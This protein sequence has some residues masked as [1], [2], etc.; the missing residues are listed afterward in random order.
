MRPIDRLVAGFL[1]VLMAI[2]GLALWIAVPAAVLK[3]L[4]PLSDSRGYHL[5]I[6]LIGV[7]VAMIAFGIALFWI[8]GLYL[9]IT[10]YWQVDPDGAPRRLRGPLE[11][12]LI[13]SLL[14]ALVA[15]LFW[16]FALAENPSPQVI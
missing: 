11:Q 7:P 16:F 10:G 13:W 9:R 6:G 12:I 4:I 14:F 3:A 1:L 2:G 15:L 5:L 8:N